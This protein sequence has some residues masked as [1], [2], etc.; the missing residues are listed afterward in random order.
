MPL[1]KMKCDKCGVIQRRVLSH[2]ETIKGMDFRCL[3]G[4]LFV[5]QNPEPT[6][7][8]MERL[9]NGAMPRAV[10]RYT[11][12]EQLMQERHL[13]ADPIAGTKKNYS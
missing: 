5:K 6:T 1:Y 9:D 13:N 2:Y 7:Q 3:C 12:A 11:D 4:G 10:E 8:S